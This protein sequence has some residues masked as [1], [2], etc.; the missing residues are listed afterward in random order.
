MLAGVERLRRIRNPGG[1]AEAEIAA[2]A[3]HYP[4]P[5][6]D[7]GRTLNLLA[8]RRRGLL[9]LDL[10]GLAVTYWQILSSETENIKFNDIWVYLTA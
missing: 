8:S 1:A 7:S 3:T 10:S 2:P 9:R 4:H 5:S 6:I